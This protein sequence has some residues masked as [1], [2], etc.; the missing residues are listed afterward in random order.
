MGIMFNEVWTEA[1]VARLTELWAS[2]MSCAAIASDLKCF[3][4]CGDNGRSAVIGKIH[5][6]KLPQPSG[7]MHRSGS[8][9]QR[10]RAPREAAPTQSNH[11]FLAPPPAPRLRNGHDPSQR[12]N[13]SQNILASIALAET[14]PGLPETLKGDAPDGTGVKFVDLERGQ[15]KWPK[16]SPGEPDVEFCGCRA[17]PDLPYCAHHTR[18]AIAPTQSR[19]RMERAI[20]GTEV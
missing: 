1:R 16:G 8:H 2:G 17:L 19:N 12:R 5:R 6:L 18:K 4:H 14:E 3:E 7:K 20:A 9:I 11:P 13:P 10:P 15:C